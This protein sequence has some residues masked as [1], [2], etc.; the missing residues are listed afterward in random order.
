MAA[1]ASDRSPNVLFLFTDDQRFDTIQ[2]VNNSRIH[3][4]N[5]D[6]LVQ[7]GAVFENAYIMGGTSP[8]VCMPSRAM[9]MTGRS[10]FSIQEQ[11]QA[12]P[13]E[14]T[15]LG[16]CFRGHGYDTW[17]IGK[18]HNGK[19]SYARSF[20]DGAEIYFGGM[21]D[22]W[23]VP[24]Y[25]FDPSG[26]YDSQLPYC[27]SPGSSNEVQYRNADHIH[28]G[29]HSSELC[30]DAAVSFLQNEIRQ[31]SPF[32]LYVSFLAPHDPRTM[33]K[34]SRDLY[35]PDSIPLPANFMGAHPF[36]NGELKIRDEQLEDWPRTPQ[37]VRR[38]IAEYYAMISHLDS[39]IGRILDALENSGEADNTVVVLAGDNGLAV[40]QHGLMG[41]Q[42]LYEHSVHV[43]L[44]FAGPGVPVGE[45]RQT[46]CYLHDMFP[47]LCELCNVPVPR[48]VEGQSLVPA[49]NNDPDDNA[50]NVLHFAYRHSQ[51]A[52]RDERYK[53]IECVVEDDHNTQLFDLENDPAETDNLAFLPEYADIVQRLRQELR[54]WKIEF[55]DER[56]DAGQVFWNR[57]GRSITH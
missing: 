23:N 12:I 45:R 32:L 8:A 54:R 4:P 33:P 24:A 47:T 19:A 11:G 1:S 36:D 21:A 38:H 9:V 7:Q 5:L 28:S 14:H 25:N 51:R 3:T 29:K 44:I 2:A 34:S 6:R 35:H 16:E 49:L 26:K 10:L 20:T 50:R 27:P 22:H 48:S 18:W 30:A 42:S 17:G 52:V 56:A 31:D 15:L 13:A 53:L 40:G 43:P 46:L 55:G 41:K 37:A 39:E 57:Y